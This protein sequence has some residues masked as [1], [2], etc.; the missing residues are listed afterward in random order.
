MFFSK[1]GYKKTVLPGLTIFDI[2]PTTDAKSWKQ[3]WNAV[4]KKGI[5]DFKDTHKT[6][7]GKLYEVEVFAQFF[8]NNGKERISA[9]I[10]EITGMGY[11]TFVDR[12][13]SSI[14]ADEKKVVAGALRLCRTTGTPARRTI[15]NSFPTQALPTPFVVI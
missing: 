3:H 7:K 6:R 15:R 10:N 2:N 4:K 11:S 1:M 5:I 8:S 12:L 9:I 13:S 14:S